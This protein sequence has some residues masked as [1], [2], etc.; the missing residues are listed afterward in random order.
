MPGLSIFAWTVSVVPLG[1]A[2]AA[3]ASFKAFADRKVRPGA[4]AAL[5]DR[6]TVQDVLGRAETR[7]AAAR[8]LLAEAM[9]TLMRSTD[10]GGDDL[11]RSRVAFRAACAF[12]AESAV[13]IVDRLA[14]AA[15]A[16]AIFETFALERCVR[17]V[18]AAAQHIAM[19]PNN[20]AVAG[21]LSLGRDLQVARF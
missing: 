10:A 13:E 19:S 16:A 11:V 8:A 15:G 2:S 14:T 7:H 6:E 17:D 20:Y 4:T 5:A 3:I 12:A 1:I 21:R 9:T 18:R